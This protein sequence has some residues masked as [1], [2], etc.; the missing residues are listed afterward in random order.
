MPKEVLVFFFFSCRSRHTR[1]P[2]DWSSDVCSSDLVELRSTSALLA[3]GTPAHL[4]RAARRPRPP[5]H[6][7]LR[8]ARERLPPEIGRASWRE[9]AAMKEVR[10]E[11]YKK[12]TENR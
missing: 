11:G 3:G 9:R 2:R 5:A 1:W 8:G 4:P 6:R 12:I 7:A 10:E